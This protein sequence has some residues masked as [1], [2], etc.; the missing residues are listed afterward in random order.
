MSAPRWIDEV[1]A[2]HLYGW[3]EVLC[4]PDIDGEHRCPVLVED[5]DRPPWSQGYRLPNSGPIGRGLFCPNYSSE[6]HARLLL[7]RWCC[8]PADPLTFPRFSDW[9]RYVAESTALALVL[10]LIFAPTPDQEQQQ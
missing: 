9:C 1:I 8:F 10:R 5:P 3:T 7:F 6:H 4:P 2:E